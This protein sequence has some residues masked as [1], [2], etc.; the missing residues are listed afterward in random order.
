M[1]GEI[2]TVKQTEFPLRHVAYSTISLKDNTIKEHIINNG[3]GCNQVFGFAYVPKLL[4]TNCP[5]TFKDQNNTN[6]IIISMYIPKN[7][8]DFKGYKPRD[9][10]KWVTFLN[11][12]TCFKSEFIGLITPESEKSIVTSFGDIFRNGNINYRHLANE[13]RSFYKINFLRSNYI[14]QKHLLAG[15]SLV[16]CLYSP[17]YINYIETV[18][19]ILKKDKTADPFIV[20][21]M[22]CFNP[23]IG[24]NMI[25]GR[26]VASNPPIF[27][28]TSTIA[29]YRYSSGYHL[30]YNVGTLYKV[31]TMLEFLNKIKNTS[32]NSCFTTTNNTGIGD[33]QML[34]WLTKGDHSYESF[35]S[36]CSKK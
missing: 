14:S 3:G 12:N 34:S 23:N 32:I 8:I 18:Y 36:L 4:G 24:I 27:D 15:M 6:N 30:L 25:H 20:L 2:K 10:K 16:R 35:I 21:Q 29:K 7:Y 22:A 1:Y 17:N 5:E 26:I 31:T 28:N 19:D 9:I 33:S 13:S 11:K